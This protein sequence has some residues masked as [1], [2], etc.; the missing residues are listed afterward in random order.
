M[1]YHKNNPETISAMFTSIAENYDTTNAVLSLNMHQKWNSTLVRD[2]LVKQKPKVVLDLCCGTGAIIFEYLKNIQDPVKAYLLDFSEGMLE[3]AKKR[4]NQPS[5]LKHDLNYLKADA[6]QIPLISESVDC[7]TMAYGIRN[8]KDPEKCIGEIY[9]VLTSGGTVG[10]LELTQP[11]NRI[12]R[13]GHF[14][15]LHTLLPILGKLFTS[16]KAAYQYLCKSIS[17]FAPEQLEVMMQTAGFKQI[18]RKSLFFGVAT[19]LTGKK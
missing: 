17:S 16:N 2:V 11:K 14:I 12:M 8:V 9:R 5:L 3:H 4:A 15:Y 10:I 1:T 13:L 18:E 19:L 6:Q 7:V